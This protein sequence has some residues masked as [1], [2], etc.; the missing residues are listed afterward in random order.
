MFQGRQ[1]EKKT[2]GTSVL[3]NREQEETINTQNKLFAVLFYLY[4]QIKEKKSR[5]SI[6]W[7]AEVKY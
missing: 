3:I 2:A 5:I 4:S 1:L 7:L 6:A